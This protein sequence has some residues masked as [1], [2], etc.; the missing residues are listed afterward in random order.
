VTELTLADRTLD[1]AGTGAGFELLVKQNFSLRFEVGMSL[2]ELRD[3]TLEENKRLV[4]PAG[5]IQ[6]YL[7]SSFAW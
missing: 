6:Y 1:I 5:E 7:S 3:E 2:A 4:Y